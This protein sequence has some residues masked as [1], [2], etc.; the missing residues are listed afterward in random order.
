MFT[1]PVLTAGS[2]IVKAVDVTELRTAVNAVRTLAGTG[3]FGFTDPTLSGIPIKAIHLTQLRN[4]LDAARSSLTLS[5]AIYSTP[6]VSAGGVVR[7]ANIDDL[8]I[9]VR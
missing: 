9:G 1:Q 6:A 7:K 8:R 2:T 3:P 4:Q 5:Q